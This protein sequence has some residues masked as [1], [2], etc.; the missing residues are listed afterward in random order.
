[1]RY[2]KGKIGSPICNPGLRMLSL[3]ALNVGRVGD[4]SYSASRYRRDLFET[5]GGDLIFGRAGLGIAK[6]TSQTI[7][8]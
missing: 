7:Q 5:H 6:R 4:L 3:F 1:M 2:Q 8:A